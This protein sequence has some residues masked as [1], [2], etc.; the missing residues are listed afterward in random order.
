MDKRPARS[1]T[2]Q[3]LRSGAQLGRAIVIALSI[4]AV[5]LVVAVLPAEYGI[6]PTGI[7]ERIGLRRQAPALIDMSVAVTAEAAATVQQ[8]PVPF[9]ADQLTLALKP[10]ETVEIK[11]TMNAG[12]SYVFSWSAAGGSVDFD[13]HGAPMDGGKEEASYWKGEAAAGGHGSFRAPFAGQHGWF[14]QNTSWEPVTVTLKTSGF[15]SK[16]ERIAN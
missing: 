13:M 11:A 5:I 6:D 3:P 12:D 15:Y 7:G 16:I 4:A 2:A 1:D 10:G 14:W 8:S 9:R